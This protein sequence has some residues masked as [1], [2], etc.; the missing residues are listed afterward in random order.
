MLERLLVDHEGMN[1][2]AVAPF[3]SLPIT[4]SV[5]SYDAVRNNR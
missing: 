3:L 5:A 4:T 2:E 1:E